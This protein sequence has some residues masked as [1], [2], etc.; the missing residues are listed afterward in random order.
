[1]LLLAEAKRAPKG[2][3]HS[4]RRQDRGR[5]TARAM[6]GGVDRSLLAHQVLRADI[7][8]FSQKLGS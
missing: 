5:I 6:A 7:T 8:K 3:R 4:A 1:M 2:R